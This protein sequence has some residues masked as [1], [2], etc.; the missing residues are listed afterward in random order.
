MT[1]VNSSIA[2]VNPD[3]GKTAM[4]SEMIET[5]ASAINL[6]VEDQCKEFLHCLC[7]A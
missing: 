6:E 3:L 5:F 2:G 7:Y 4:I 1:Q